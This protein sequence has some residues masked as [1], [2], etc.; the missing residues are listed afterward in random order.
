MNTVMTLGD[1]TINDLALLAALVAFGAVLVVAA[2]WTAAYLRVDRAL[3]AASRD[4]GST[5]KTIV[6]CIMCLGT[7]AILLGAVPSTMLLDAW[8]G[9]IAACWVLAS[10]IALSAASVRTRAPASTTAKPDAQQLPDS[11]GKAA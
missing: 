2:L 9:G 8:V 4:V 3:Q 7:A 10:L 6:A 5:P 11:V 1:Q